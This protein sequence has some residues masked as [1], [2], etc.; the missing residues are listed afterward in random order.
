[1][2]RARGQRQAWYTDTEVL[3]GSDQVA[4]SDSEYRPFATFS[5]GSMRDSQEFRGSLPIGSSPAE[6]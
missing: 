3:I 5:S 4:K 2:S 6:A 1:M